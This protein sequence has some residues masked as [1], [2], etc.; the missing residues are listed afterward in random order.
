MANTVLPF[1]GHRVSPDGA[2]TPAGQ[3]LDSI[4]CACD[5]IRKDEGTSMLFEPGSLV[6]IVARQ[7]LF[8]LVLVKAAMGRRIG[9]LIEQ[10]GN[11]AF[12]A[13]ML[14]A[15]T[16]SSRRTPCGRH[17]H[18][19]CRDKDVLRTVSLLAKDRN[20]GKGV[21]TYR[22][23]PCSSASIRSQRT[24]FGEGILCA[25]K[26]IKTPKFVIRHVQE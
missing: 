14:K 17:N 5:R 23:K 19:E 10:E 6:W 2:A 3:T 11:A 21:C 16:A 8:M 13:A 26:C 4:T 24:K 1:D 12:I 9:R 22:E 15:M 25:E 20:S 7:R 18:T